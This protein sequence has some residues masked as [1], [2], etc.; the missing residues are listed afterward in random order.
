VSGYRD[1]DP[2]HLH[3]A[4]RPILHEHRM[5]SAGVPLCG[6]TALIETHR[7]RVLQDADF[8]RGRGRDGKVIDKT[9]VVTESRGGES[10]HGLYRWV[11]VCP[12]CNHDR[13]QHLAPPGGG[14]VRACDAAGHQLGEHCVCTVDSLRLERFGRWEQ[15][16]ASLAYHL[17]LLCA[18]C[19]PPG[20]LLGFGAHTRLVPA[21]LLRYRKLGEIGAKLGLRWGGDWDRDGIALEPRE[22]DLTHFEFQAGG[23][24]KHVQAALSIRGGDLV[25]RAAPAP[26]GLTA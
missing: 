21:D 22:N 11:F 10:W 1:R 18:G 12:D 26:G 6:P 23:T 8:A 9:E 5:Q 4:V 19:H 2:M 20:S 14:D 15:W 7:T 17:A 16:P 13:A 25:W 24:L 3:P